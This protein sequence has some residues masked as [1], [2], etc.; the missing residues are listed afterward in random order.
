MAS[1]PKEAVKKIVAKY[2]HAKI[3][4]DAAAVMA[5]MLEK[6]AREIAAYA[7]KNAKKN[8]HASV[9]KEDVQEYIFKKGV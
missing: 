8:K 2:A 3:T 7:V 4:D 5:S 6:K 9:T 1:L